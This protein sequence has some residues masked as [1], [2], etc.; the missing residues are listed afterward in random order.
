M[1]FI[2]ID[3]SKRH[4]GLC[5][6]VGTEPLFWEI[7]PKYD[8]VLDC[9][10]QTSEELASW[11]CKNYRTNDLICME[12]QM[13]I[14]GQMAALMFCVQMGVLSTIKHYAPLEEMKLVMPLPIQL[15]SYMKKV[16]NLD[17][18]SKAAIVAGF[19]QKTGWE[20]RISSHKVDAYYLALLAKDVSL[21]SWQY[22]IPS[23]E[24]KL[25]EGTILNGGCS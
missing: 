11:L 21:G 17:I 24:S 1:N 18:T 2:G 13:S 14:G 5:L 15:K 12:R 20:K 10:G 8:N 6:L 4:T 23:K 22:K 25:F 7:R 9:L 3:P 16:H 19:K